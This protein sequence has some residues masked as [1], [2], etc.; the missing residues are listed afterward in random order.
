LEMARLS[1]GAG[2]LV[3]LVAHSDAGSQYTSVRFTERLDEIGARPSIGTVAD[4]YDNALS[5]TVNGLYKAECVY[6]PDAT[7]GVL[8]LMQ[9]IH[10]GFA[11][12]RG[13]VGVVGVTACSDGTGVA[14]GGRGRARRGGLG[15]WRGRGRSVR[16]QG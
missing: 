7:W 1:R 13:G 10:R 14:S 16:R 3:G 2:R 8:E 6:G 12:H 5:E 15:G 4:S 11:P 9:C